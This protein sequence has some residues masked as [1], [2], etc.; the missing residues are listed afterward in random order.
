MS[1]LPSVVK[2]KRAF[3]VPGGKPPAWVMQPEANKPRANI[4]FDFLNNRVWWYNRVSAFASLLSCARAAP[5]TTYYEQADGTLITFAA[6]VLRIGNRGLLSEETRTNVV[7]WNRD[8]TNAAWTKT[9]VTAALDQTGVDGVANA[10]TSLTATANDGTVTQA[11]TLA[12]SARW[13]TCYIKRI[14]GSGAISMSMDGGSTY[15]VVTVTNAWKRVALATQTISNPAPTFKMATS[16]DVIAIDFVQNEN[17]GIQATSPIATTT[18]AVA[19][20]ADV[21][22]LRSV[23]FQNPS[24]IT[25]YSQGWGNTPSSVT[26][27]CMYGGYFSGGSGDFFIRQ[28]SGSVTVFLRSRASAILVN[29]ALT[30]YTDGVRHKYVIAA[31]PGANGAAYCQE[32][33]LLQTSSPTALPQFDSFAIGAQSNSGSWWNGYVERVA[34]WNRRLPNEDVQLLSAA[35]TDF[36]YIQEGDS[37]P[38]Q[39]GW[40]ANFP[41]YI[42]TTLA[43]LGWAVHNLAVSGSS[44]S[45]STAAVD[46][47]GA[48]RLATLAG[49]FN[50]YCRANANNPNFKSCT[51]IFDGHND[52]ALDGDS[53]STFLSQMS[54]YLAVL[55]GTNRNGGRHK[56]AVC[57]VPPST[58]PADFNTWRGGV[59]P[60]LATYPSVYC[61][62]Y[63]D[64][65]GA[66][67]FLDADA[68]N[69]SYWIDGI[70]PSTTQAQQ[71]IAPQIKSQALD[72]AAA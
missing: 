65:T 31:Q 27:G 18:V 13:Q 54:A 48:T 40:P 6:N 17:S 43:P 9:N 59:N 51:V 25:V 60:T 3:L 26:Q 28:G 22:L 19:R 35:N 64:L 70:H 68:S 10:A 30:G 21:I 66:T 71:V 63:V 20:S 12:S 42:H 67:G 37:I 52:K 56:L 45:G 4:D 44:L 34:I 58:S 2:H 50:R 47:S 24:A 55:R 53:T 29:D 57:T 49:V 46:L 61:D 72:P 33:G 62:Y 14:S 23:P 1:R 32:T 8:M 7:L 15:T 38:Q 36:L 11:I 5:A 39:G 69:T 16:G 41:G